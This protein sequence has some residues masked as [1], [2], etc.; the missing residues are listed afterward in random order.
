[1]RIFGFA[2]RTMAAA[3]L[4]AAAPSADTRS[5]LLRADPVRFDGELSVMTYNIHGLP[6][7]V[8][9]GRPADFARIAATLQTLRAE[10]RNP[11]VVLLQEAF[12]DEA[13]AVGR[14][15]GYRYIA[16]GPD[17][18]AANA[19]RPT[20]GDL[21]F[22]ADESWS[23]GEGIGKFVG[24]GL[25]ILSDFPIVSVRGMVFPRYACAG[26]DCLANKGAMLARIRLPDRPDPVDIVT[27]HLNSRRASRVPDLRSNH[28]HSLQ[29]ACLT[30]FIRRWHDP[31]DALIVAGD[32]NAGQTEERRSDLVEHADR[33]W[34]FGAPMNNAYAA[35]EELGL[36]LS[37]DARLS[38]RR[39]RDWEFFAP[40]RDTDVALRRIEVPFGHAADGAMLSDHVGYTAV[41][42]L[43]R[44]AVTR[45][46]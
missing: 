40:G 33:D 6:W 3:A 38:E 42:G 29:I 18:D 7:P 41:F 10:G 14:A 25:Q 16:N 30:A 22:A 27:T 43:Q 45:T 44:R 46:S 28:A 15:A 2:L 12:T 31:R 19:Q 5:P 21:R 36:P 9:W 23:H 39:A 11:H 17:E 24:S 1:M 4:I 8:A 34:S 26:F 35:A 32:F 13:Q 20:P 37:A